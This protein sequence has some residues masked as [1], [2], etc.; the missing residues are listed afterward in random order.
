MK[1]SGSATFELDRPFQL[2]LRAEPAP[3]DGTWTTERTYMG[4]ELISVAP[5]AYEGRSYGDII[6]NLDETVGTVTVACELLDAAPGAIDA[7]GWDVIEETGALFSGGTEMHTYAAADDDTRLERGAQAFGA[8][9]GWHMVRVSA[10]AISGSTP[11]AAIRIQVWPTDGPHQLERLHSREYP[12]NVAHVDDDDHGTVQPGAGRLLDTYIGDN[13]SNSLLIRTDFSDD[14]TWRYLV[15]DELRPDDAAAA[16]TLT[17]IDN[18][19]YDGLTVDELMIQIADGPPLYVFLADT[20][21]M[22]ADDHSILAVDTG[23]EEFGHTPGQTLRLTP[24]AMASVD[25]NL[26]IGNM[27]FSDFVTAADDANTFDGFD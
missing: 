3:Q 10:H 9:S 21:T 26:A 16:A 1:P 24:R 2:R 14:D 23:P 15:R 25:N 11:D 13:Y 8:A 27:S 20:T 7:S 12:L 22:T 17:V 4:G 18:P 19:V 5:G 6:V